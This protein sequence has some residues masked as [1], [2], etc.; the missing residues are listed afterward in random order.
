MDH[1]AGNLPNDRRHAF[2]FN[3]FY[4]INNAFSVGFNAIVASGMPINKFSIHPTGVDSCAD[5]SVWSDCNSR[6]YGQVSFYDENG[7]PA[8]R[9]SAGTTNWQKSLDF[10]F[11]YHTTIAEGDLLLKATVYNVL[12]DDTQTAVQQQRAQNG[13]NGLELN[14][15]WGRT[16]GRMGARYVSFVAK[17]SF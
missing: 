15:N 3:G 17:Y 12:N 8:P 6:D 10:S 9:G 14:P 11:A 13:T 1:S 2:K 4:N 16:I 5:G 7:T